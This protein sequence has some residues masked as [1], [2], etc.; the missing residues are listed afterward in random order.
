MRAIA[1]NPTGAETFTVD[2]AAMRLREGPAY[3]TSLA[4][5]G[6]IDAVEVDGAWIFDGAALRAW[7]RRQRL[8]ARPLLRQIELRGGD[9]AL[10]VR[11]GSAEKRALERARADGWVTESAGDHLAVHVLRMTPFEVWGPEFY[12]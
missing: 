9:Y 2:E 11:I 3:V 1:P 12:G 4:A 8:P 7:E 6:A 5:W 10:G